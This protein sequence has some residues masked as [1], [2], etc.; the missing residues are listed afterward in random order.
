M[1]SL[2]YLFIVLAGLGVGASAYFGLTFTPI[3]SLVTAVA[4]VAVAVILLERTLRRRAEARLERA[5]ED[6]SRLLSTDAQA[7]AVLGQRINALT[8]VDAGRR[9]EVVEA[10]L[11]VLGTVVRQVAEAVADLEEARKRQA[12]REAGAAAAAA[13]TLAPPVAAPPEPEP[14]PEPAAEASRPV[15]PAPEPE[16]V[17]PLETLRQALD[18]NRLIF[19]L[20]PIVTLPQ[21]RA[22]GYDLLP[23]LMLEEGELA[24]PP[25]FMP[26]R[27][28][29]AVIRRIE[30]QALE[31]AITIARR[32]RTN[33]RPATLYVPVS[34]A[35]LTDPVLID[36]IVT[37]LDANRAVAGF[38]SL[39]LAEADWSAMPLSEKAALAAFV[40]Q[41]VSLSLA[42]TRSLRLD[43]AD[44]AAEGIRSVRVDARRFIEAPEGLTD[45]HASDIAGYVKR[46]GVD[47]IA[48]GI[49]TEDQILTLL[50]DGVGLAQ[51]PHIAGPGPARSDLVVERVSPE[52]APSRAQA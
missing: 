13:R 42:G 10:D 9:L 18:D 19:H 44:L 38:I 32:A 37:M 26:R 12:R 50:E 7:G 11:S 41:G 28:G 31:E 39:K 34:R 5:I 15:A 4:F 48:T 46:F 17:I 43:F 47:L 1:Q 49:D 29:A 30:Q 35:S 24:D 22:H 2:V 27:G 36:K 52:A 40:K 23:R 20:Q 45:F 25:D 33:G 8:D 3:E 14:Q 21:R 6:L 16:P 51:G